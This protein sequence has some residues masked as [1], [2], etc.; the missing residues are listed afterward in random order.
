MVMPWLPR[1][2]L[3]TIPSPGSGLQHPPSLYSRPS[4]PR[5]G[6]PEGAGA[7]GLSGVEAATAAATCSLLGSSLLDSL[8][9]RISSR[10]RFTT[11]CTVTPPK[12]REASRSSVATRLQ[13]RATFCIASPLSRASKPSR[14]RS[15]SSISVPRWMFSRR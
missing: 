9:R 7:A 12:P 10:S 2:T 6:L 4:T 15:R 13:R 8:A 5:I 1:A 11:C 3:P 14:P